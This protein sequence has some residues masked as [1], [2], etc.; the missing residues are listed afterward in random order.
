RWRSFWDTGALRRAR[1]AHGLG[2]S[3][4]S[5]RPADNSSLASGAIRKLGG[6]RKLATTQLHH[7]MEGFDL[8]REG[9]AD[10]PTLTPRKD[11][12]SLYPEWQSS[13]HAWP[14]RSTSI[15]ASAATPASLRATSRTT[16]SSSAR[17]RS[18]GVARCCGCGSIA[19]TAAMWKLPAAF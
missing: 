3:A 4:Y 19:T 10:H 12:T 13:D 2:Y 9:S 15:S 17:I 16:C 18:P 11:A 14:W 7:R 8:V 6:S 5:V 1:I